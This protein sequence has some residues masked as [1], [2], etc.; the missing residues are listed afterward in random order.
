MKKYYIAYGS[1]LN[2]VQMAYRCPR[3]RALGSGKIRDWSL[4]FRGSKTGSYLTIDRRKGACVPVGVWEI[5]EADER[6]LD[7]YEGCPTFYYKTTLPVTYSDAQG[8]RRDVEAIV[9]IMHEDR[10][11]GVPSASYIRTCAQ[12]Y[13]DFGLDLEYLKDAVLTAPEL[14]RK[15]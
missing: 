6:A 15:N 13:V 14:A 2:K 10:P 4:A 11:L 5:T 7:R 8:D 3:A 12:G 9:Y 1:N